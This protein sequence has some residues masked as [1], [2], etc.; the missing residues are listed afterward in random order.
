VKPFTVIGDVAP[1]PFV[2]TP[3]VEEVQLTVLFVIAEPFVAPA[4]NAMLAFDTAPDTVK[5]RVTLEMVGAPG[6]VYGVT[7]L[8]A[9]DAEP[10]PYVL[11]AVTVNVYAVPAVR[12]DT[13]QGDAALE[14]NNPPGEAV[15]LYD[16]MALPP[17]EEGA[18]H[19][20]A[21]DVTP[22]TAVTDVGAP[23]I[24]NG[25][26]DADALESDPQPAEFAALTTQVCATPYV[27]GV[28]EAVSVE[29]PTV[30]VAAVPLVGVHV[31]W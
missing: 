21:A 16:V 27:A 3:P 4:V 29:P 13:V 19:D 8:D 24:P 30:A 25:V 28:T 26:I 12:P 9:A 17:F 20:T 11:V 10:V 14:Q 2:A 22:A 31:T 23:G 18:V 1:E 15:A 7:L 5:P 6:V